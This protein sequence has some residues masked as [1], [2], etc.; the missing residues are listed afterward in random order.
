MSDGRKHSLNDAVAPHAGAWIEIGVSLSN[1]A[2]LAVAPHAGAW[3][4][5]Y[6]KALQKLNCLCRAGAWIEIISARMNL[7]QF[8]VAPHAG[9]WIEMLP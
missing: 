8:I 9:A 6:G 2:A 1:A 5:I 4:E 7:I 3:I